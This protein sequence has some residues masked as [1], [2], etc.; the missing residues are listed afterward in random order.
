MLPAPR[1][2][3]IMQD[4]Q[5]EQHHKQAEQHQ[6]H[7]AQHSSRAINDSLSLAKIL[8]ATAIEGGVARGDLVL[9][10]GFAAD[11]IEMS[12]KWCYSNLGRRGAVIVSW[13]FRI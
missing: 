3:N 1:K 6:T 11:E 7:L 13:R 5:S 12:V 8:N 4:K 10:K 9:S 2:K